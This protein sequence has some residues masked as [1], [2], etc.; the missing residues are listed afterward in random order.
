MG[1]FHLLTNVPVKTELADMRQVD[2][3]YLTELDRVTVLLHPLRLQ[4]LELAI[5][6][7]SGTEAARSLGLPRQMVNY[8]VAALE[9]AG[10]LIRI[11]DVRR[12]NMVERRLQS[13]ARGY[14]ISPDILGNLSGA[15][16]RI[17]DHGSSTALLSLTARVQSDLGVAVQAERGEPATP[18]LSFSSKISF[19]DDDA[20]REFTRAL[21]E[22]VVAVVREYSAPVQ[23]A[24]RSPQYGLVLGLYSL[25][26]TSSQSPE[27]EQ[28]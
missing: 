10:F 4:I 5:E 6:E 21:G 11:G 25:P 24:G 7:T 18:A 8:H 28:R 17:P 12:R 2:I 14:L 22:S 16:R 3:E 1:E 13:S 9:K 26:R 23:S 15:R 19:A 20:R 27:G